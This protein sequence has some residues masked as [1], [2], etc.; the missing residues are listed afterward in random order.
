M[1][2]S[3]QIIVTFEQFTC[4]PAEFSWARAQLYIQGPWWAALSRGATRGLE[5][6]RVFPF[7]ALPLPHHHL[8]SLSSCQ[9]TSRKH[10]HYHHRHRSP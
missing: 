7:A 1:S 6:Y 4:I 3:H 5:S 10:E 9:C 8:D 2:L